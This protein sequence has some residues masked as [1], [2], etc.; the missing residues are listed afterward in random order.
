MMG[1]ESGAVLESFGE[2]IAAGLMKLYGHL[3][4]EPAF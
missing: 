2:F 4:T 3:S 1:V